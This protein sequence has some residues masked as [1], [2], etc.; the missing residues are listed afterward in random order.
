MKVICVLLSTEDYF[1]DLYLFMSGLSKLVFTLV[2]SALLLL[3]KKNEVR[4]IHKII[5]I[6]HIINNF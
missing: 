5:Q 1:Y 6:K 4:R 2:N 3:E